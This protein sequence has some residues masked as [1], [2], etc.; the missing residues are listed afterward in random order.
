MTLQDSNAPWE[1]VVARRWP[2][3]L[4]GVLVAA[5]GL[6][7]L[8]AWLAHAGFAPAP[9]TELMLWEF[10][11]WGAAFAGVSLLGVL[12]AAAGLVRRMKGPSPPPAD[13][14]RMDAQ[15][16]ERREPPRL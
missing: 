14:Y 9:E 4:A 11:G 10:A 13:A 1:H 15:A 5:L 3:W 6:P 12:M 7:V 2:R 16:P 8:R